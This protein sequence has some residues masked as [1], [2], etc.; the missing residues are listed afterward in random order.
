MKIHMLEQMEPFEEVLMETHP[1]PGYIG[2]ALQGV[3]CNATTMHPGQEQKMQGK[4]LWVEGGAVEKSMAW[5]NDKFIQRKAH[6]ITYY[7]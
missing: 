1:H 6:N 2:I 5:D 4:S 7:I 3:V